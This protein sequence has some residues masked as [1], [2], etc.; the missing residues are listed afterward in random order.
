MFSNACFYEWKLLTFKW[1]FIEICSLGLIDNISALIIITQFTYVYYASPGLN[2][3]IPFTGEMVNPV[4][5]STKVLIMIRWPT[6]ANNNRWIH[7]RKVSNIR[8]TKSQNLIW[9]SSRL[10]VVFA[11]F[12]EA[13]CQVENEDAVGAAPRGDA[14]TTSEWSTIWLPTQVRLTLEFWR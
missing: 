13:R 7:Y 12:I 6:E 2:E 11:Q 4:F 10:A 1:Y 5:T 8:R 3:L 9:F 14:P